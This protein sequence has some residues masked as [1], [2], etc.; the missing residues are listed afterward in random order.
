MPWCLPVDIGRW[1]QLL[2]S[3]C[4]S[5]RYFETSVLLIDLDNEELAWFPTMRPTVFGFQYMLDLLSEVPQCIEE[6]AIF[7]R[8]HD[9]GQ[10]CI[11]MVSQDYDWDRLVAAIY[12]F[13]LIK[14]VNIIILV[15]EKFS[16]DEAYQCQKI[17]VAALHPKLQEQRE[18][19]IIIV[20]YEVGKYDEIVRDGLQAVLIM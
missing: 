9:Q 7:L 6:L 11:D 13:R 20:S 10:S 19:V 18:T 1:K 2:L 15:A 14:V 12:S 8:L 3:S 5:L 17:I 16:V 4:H